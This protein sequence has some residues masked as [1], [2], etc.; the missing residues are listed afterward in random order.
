MKEVMS[1]P[2][3]GGIIISSLDDP[4]WLGWEKRSW[5]HAGVQVHYVT[6]RQNGAI[7]AVDD[8]KFTNP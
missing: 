7:I 2:E 5:Y 8:F 3:I 4:R 1:K 6:K